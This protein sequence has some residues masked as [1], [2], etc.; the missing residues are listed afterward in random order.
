MAWQLALAGVGF[1]LTLAPIAAAAVNAS[2]DEQRGSAS[3]LVIIFRLVGMTVGV[4]ALA[5]YG[6][7]RAETLATRLLGPGADLAASAA[8]GM[9]I[10]SQVINETFL[11]AAG[12][13]LL[14]CLPAIV[15]KPEVL[16][17]GTR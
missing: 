6:L 9:K 5:S 11:I 10:A 8:A 16:E 13:C 3:G 17:G 2:P 1:G 4:S 14:A 15:L 12:V 7:Q